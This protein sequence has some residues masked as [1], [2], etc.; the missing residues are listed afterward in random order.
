MPESARAAVRVTT[1]T[2][3][4]PAPSAVFSDGRTPTATS[5]DAITTNGNP[6]G[7]AVFV[8]AGADGALQSE[9]CSDWAKQLPTTD[10]LGRL[11]E[12]R[13]HPDASDY[14]V[15]AWMTLLKQE[16]SRRDSL[17]SR[18]G[19]AVGDVGKHAVTQIKKFRPAQVGVAGTASRQT[20]QATPRRQ[21]R[22][23]VQGARP[24]GSRQGPTQAHPSPG[25]RARIFDRLPALRITG[26]TVSTSV[27]GGTTAG[28]ALLA[29]ATDA[30]VS[31]ALLGRAVAEVAVH[32][33]Y[34]PR[35]P[36][37]ELFLMEVLNYSMAS[38]PASKTS[39]LAGLSR[40]SQQ[41]MRHATWEQ[42]AKDPLVKAIQQIFQTLGLR[43]TH[44]R[45]ANVVP[46]AGGVLSA[47]LSFRALGS[48][49]DD[50]TR[51]YRARYLADKHGLNWGEWLQQPHHFD[52]LAPDDAVT[53]GDVVHALQL[54]TYS[55][56]DAVQEKEE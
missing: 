33:G 12:D 43:L 45:L 23:S 10:D 46:V 29:V 18:A 35:E 53:A 32:Y 22:F 14:E 31:L 7:Q 42:F 55:G 11:M 13:M 34:D 15:R 17:T 19:N 48:A 47:G 28:G 20:T 26:L 21:G 6:S 38:G 56:N 40:L 8:I 2:A 51:V 5:T 44:Q 16:R 52:K 27:S 41:M 39:A 1:K 30:V 50:A 37:E 25:R 54:D 4:V 24:Q 49:I 36:E 9:R 3:E